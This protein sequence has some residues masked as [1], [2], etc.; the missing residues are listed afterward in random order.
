MVGLPRSVGVALPLESPASSEPVRVSPLLHGAVDPEE[1]VTLAHGA[2]E[3][4]GLKGTGRIEERA[5]SESCRGRMS[6]EGGSLGGRRGPGCVQGSCRGEQGQSAKEERS[7]HK[8]VVSH[9]GE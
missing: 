8:A 4:K 3:A 2:Q 7:G 5:C 6:Q 9:R 1:T